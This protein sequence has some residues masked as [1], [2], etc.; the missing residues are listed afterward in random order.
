MNY[1]NK[2]KNIAL[3]LKDKAF[4]KLNNISRPNIRGLSKNPVKYLFYIL[5]IVLPVLSIFLL[6]NLKIF[7]ILLIS[8]ST[9]LKYLNLCVFQ[10]LCI[11]KNKE[12]CDLKMKDLQEAIALS[13]ISFL[14]LWL[15]K[16]IY[17]LFTSPS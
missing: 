7:T 6:D 13:F 14:F 9:F 11:I 1:L 2:V 5:T 3:S 17:K 10:N 16:T 4:S 8:Y 12:K 15:S